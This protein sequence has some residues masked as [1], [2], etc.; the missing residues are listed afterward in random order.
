MRVFLT[1]LGV[2]VGVVSVVG[3]AA[4]A[5]NLQKSLE[6]QFSK[7]GN[8]TFYVMRFSYTRFMSGSSNNRSA[9]KN[10][11]NRKQLEIEYLD[12]LKEYVSSAE[13]IAPVLNYNFQVKSSNVTKSESSNIMATTD[14]IVNINGF[15]TE[16]GHFLL[17]E[18]SNRRRFVCVLGRNI[19]QE[20]FLGR[21]PLGEKVKIGGYPFTVIG[22]MD[23]LGATMEGSYDDLVI[24]PISTAMKLWGRGWWL[25]F[26][27]K[28]YPGMMDMAQ[29]EATDVL[30]RLRG[31]KF[32][33]ENDFD[34]MT[35]D[36]LLS[37]I[38]KITSVAFIVMI[39]ISAIAMVVAGIG[40]MNVMY[41]TV[42]ERTREIG[43]RK[44]VGANRNDI[45]WQFSAEAVIISAFGGLLGILFLEAVVYSLR[46][47]SIS[48]PIKVVLPLSLS[49]LG[50][51]FSFVVGV[52]FGIA[53]QEKQAS[54]ML[55]ML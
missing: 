2:V 14:E 28:A 26:A 1:S 11:F 44:S 40:I 48:I 27:I 16:Y 5:Y 33:D 29:S 8:E 13:N 54:S 37:S 39:A 6:E 24:V 18:D 36:M 45:L 47:V 3:I 52:T 7:M 21:S 49:L 22:V 34:F 25:Q 30:R 55:S 19:A 46:F 9:M 51:L 4:M 38:G 31:L 17:P 20:L 10:I 50:L 23:S 32:Q 42:S 35:A 41:V 43:I 53:P 12:D 15:T